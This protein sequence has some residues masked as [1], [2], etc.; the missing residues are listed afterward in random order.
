MNVRTIRQE[1]NIAN[2]EK[3]SMQ[4][5]ADFAKCDHTFESLIE[6]LCNLEAIEYTQEKASDTVGFVVN[7]VEYFVRLGNLLDVETEIKKVEDELNYPSRIFKFRVEKA[8]QRKVCCRS[9][10]TG[11]RSGT[12]ETGRCG[13]KNRYFATTIGESEEIKIYYQT[14]KVVWSFHTTFFSIQKITTFV[15]TKILLTMF[16]TERLSLKVLKRA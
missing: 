2:K 6:K 10:R 9:S 14:F 16:E 8:L 1:K 15:S 13:I 7:K 12:Q 5:I 11:G 4:I 3:L